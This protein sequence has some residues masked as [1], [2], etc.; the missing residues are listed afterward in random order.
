MRLQIVSNASS[1]RFRY[2]YFSMD[3][4]GFSSV[5]MVNLYNPLL[6]ICIIM[7]YFVKMNSF[8]NSIFP[9]SSIFGTFKNN[10][11]C[12]FPRSLLAMIPCK[13]GEPTHNI[14]IL[15]LTYIVAEKIEEKISRRERMEEFSLTKIM[16]NN[17]QMIY[18]V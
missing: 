12:I 17:L 18:Y 11:V 15:E 13:C 4:V 2:L 6:Q 14:S 8:G 9:L 7:F 5:F 16:N 10:L 3:D 1:I